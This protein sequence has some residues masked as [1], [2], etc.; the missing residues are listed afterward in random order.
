MQSASPLAPW[1]TISLDKGI[2]RSKL[3]A[4]RLG[5]DPD[6]KDWAI[7]QCLRKIPASRFPKEEAGI[8][9]GYAQFPFV[10]VVDGTFLT[11]SPQEYLAEGSFKKIPLL[12]GS[13]A[14]EGTWLLVY[15]EPKLFD[16]NETIKISSEKHRQVLDRLFQYHPQ[17][18]IELGQVA[19]DAVKFQYTDWL[20]PHNPLVLAGQVEQAVGDFHFVCGVVDMARTV[21]SSGQDVYMYR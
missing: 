17:H 15:H 12:M 5:C 8:T 7:L 9:R 4:K 18:P 11:K 6:D 19:K 20:R 16:L 14:N 13:N 3:L 21:A 1:A 10:P 2:D